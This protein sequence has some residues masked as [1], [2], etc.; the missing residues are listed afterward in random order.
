MSFFSA[1]GG[2]IWIKFCRLLQNDIDCGDMVKIETRCR[3]PIWQ[4]FGRILSHVLQEPPG[5]Y[6]AMIP[7]LPVTLQGAATGRI[8]WHV[9]PELRVTLQGAATGRTQRHVIPKSRITLQG[10]TTW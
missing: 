9:T 10:P 8:Q 4:T 5:E 2:P 7:E 1:G 6:N 3:I